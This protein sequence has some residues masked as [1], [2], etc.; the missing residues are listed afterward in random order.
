MILAAVAN[1][2]WEVY[3]SLSA[4]VI[5]VSC[6]YHCYQVHFLH[7]HPL[8]RPDPQAHH[9][10]HCHLH[11]GDEVGMQA[12]F[13]LAKAPR[14][15]AMMDS[16]VVENLPQALVPEKGAM[17]DWAHRKGVMED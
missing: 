3:W 17:E 10:D 15:G 11:H 1:V 7:L 2:L 14:N 6:S 4:M 16:V 5:A 9:L 8:D 13:V 12:V